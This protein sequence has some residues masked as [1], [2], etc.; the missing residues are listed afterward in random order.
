M[1]PKSFTLKSQ[2]IEIRLITPIEIC[3]SH[4]QTSTE[5]HPPV[6]KASGLW[7][8]GASCTTITSGLATALGLT[9]IGFETVYHANGSCI[10]KKYKVNIILPNGIEIPMLDVLEGNLHGFDI[11]IGMD[12]I[13][14]GDFAITHSDGKTTFTFR[15]PSVEKLDFVRTPTSPLPSAPITSPKKV[16][17]ND[18]CPCGS[19]KKYKKCC[20]RSE[21]S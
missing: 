17:R 14:Q 18:P 5:P 19:G 12:I 7:D 2:S 3:Q 10:A 8:T 4:A 20:G 6:I 13:T 21:K 16:G 15:I 1:N 9:P 11:L